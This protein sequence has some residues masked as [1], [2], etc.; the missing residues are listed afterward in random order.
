MYKK[1]GFIRIGCL[2]PN[3]KVAD[4]IYNTNELIQ[5]KKEMSKLGIYIVLTPE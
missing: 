4:V 5:K 3:I 1:Y 2:V